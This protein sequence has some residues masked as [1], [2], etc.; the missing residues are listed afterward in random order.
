MISDEVIEKNHKTFNDDV[1]MNGEI[2]YEN[3]STFPQTLDIGFNFNLDLEMQN[4]DSDSLDL[5]HR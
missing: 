1:V 5:R 2:G 4:N 3:L